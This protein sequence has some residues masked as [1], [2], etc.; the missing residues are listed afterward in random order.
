MSRDVTSSTNLDLEQAFTVLSRQ[1][2]ACGAARDFFDFA[3][4]WVRFFVVA[5]D[6]NEVI[7][8]WAEL[9]RWTRDAGDAHRSDD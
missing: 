7:V 5:T 9:R 1:L 3:R 4:A 6:L 8:A 2:A